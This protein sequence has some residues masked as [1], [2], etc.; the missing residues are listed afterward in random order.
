[1]RI[2]VFGGTFDP[3][4]IAHLAVAQDA[5]VALSL[6]RVIFV[7]AALPPHKRDTPHT[8]AA[9]RLEMLRAALEGDG[10]FTASEIEIERG[11]ASYTADTLEALARQ[12]PGD[13]L[14]L[15]IG[16]D[17]FREFATWRE[18]ER[19][20]R[21]ASLVVLSRGEPEAAA[22]AADPWPHRRVQVTRIDL[23]STALRLRVARGE[24]IRY[25]VPPAVEAI[26]RREALYAR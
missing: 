16:A 18:P 2:G 6:D 10:R 22:A 1:M 9:I 21:L 13:E 26:I 8:A 11:G 20:A 7:P 15:L 12:R 19:V 17:Q 5:F 14:F 25:L 24:P 23:S 3:P 4:H